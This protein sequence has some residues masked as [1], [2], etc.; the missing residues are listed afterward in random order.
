MHRLLALGSAARRHFKVTLAVVL[1]VGCLVL[2]FATGF[3]LLFRLAYLTAFALPLLYFWTKAM[4][5]SLDIEVQ[6]TTQRVTQGQ[7]IEGRITVRS[8]SILPK[9]WLEV[10]DPSSVPG[11]N[12]K[13]VITMGARGMASWD[14][15]TRTRVR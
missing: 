3:W 11:H 2:A 13:R 4:S 7:P 1:T 5:D 9:M 10:E 6:R 14:Y 12:A 8:R 15:R